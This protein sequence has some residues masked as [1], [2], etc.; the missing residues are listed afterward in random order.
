MSNLTNQEFP[1]KIRIDAFQ[2]TRF[3]AHGRVEKSLL[4]SKVVSFGETQMVNIDLYEAVKFWCENPLKINFG[5]EIMIDSDQFTTKTKSLNPFE[6]H[7][8]ITVLLVL[9]TTPILRRRRQPSPATSGEAC[10]FQSEVCCQFPITVRFD[11]IGLSWIVHPEMYTT[12][13]CAGTCPHR[14]IDSLAIND[15]AVIRSKLHNLNSSVHPAPCCVPTK[16]SNLTILYSTEADSPTLEIKV[17]SDFV[18][19]ECK[20]A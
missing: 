16:L 19:D 3:R 20:C 8:N 2:L 5:M 6:N 12:H 11:D 17:L 15:L 1:G 4:D 10:S 14:Y 7:D 9:E 18:V 13:Q